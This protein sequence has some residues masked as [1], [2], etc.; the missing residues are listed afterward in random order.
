MCNF[1]VRIIIRV[2]YYNIIYILYDVQRAAPGRVS[3]YYIMC[4]TN[5]FR[6]I[7]AYYNMYYVY[8]P[9]RPSEFPL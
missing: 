5:E 1:R 6:I 8:I 4:V 9:T 3:K 2:Y 7:I